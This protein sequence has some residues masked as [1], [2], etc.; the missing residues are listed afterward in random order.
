LAARWV[1]ASVETR[2]PLGTFLINILG[3]FVLG[4]LAGVLA[5]RA[6]PQADA[7]RL[8]VGVGVCGGFTTFSTFE[9]ETHALLEDGLWTIATANVLL[10]VVVGL[11]TLRFGVVLGKS[12]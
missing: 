9:F 11:V 7:L 5:S 1:G 3:S 10:S 8:L 6:V 4:L 12:L 2:F